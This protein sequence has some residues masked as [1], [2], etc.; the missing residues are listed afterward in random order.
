MKILHMQ[1]GVM[2]NVIDYC[3]DNDI[4]EII[5][6]GDL[7]DV[8]KS[9]S[10]KALAEWNSRFF[11]KLGKAG[12]SMSTVIGNHDMV[13]ENTI[14]PNSQTELLSHRRNISITHRPETKYFDGVQFL[15]IPWICKDNEEICL[16]AIKTSSAKICVL[17]PEIKGCTLQGS[18]TCEDGLSIKIF[19]HFDLVIAGHFHT[20]GVYGNVTYV[21]TPYQTSWNDYGENK[22]FH[23]LDTETA[24]MEFISVGEALCH[25]LVYDEDMD[26]SMDDILSIDLTD[27]YVKLTVENRTDFEKYDIFLAKLTDKGMAKLSVI[28]PILQLSGKDSDVTFDGDLDVTDTEEL[29]EEYIKDLYPERVT[30]LTNMMLGLHAEARTLL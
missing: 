3:V 7:F 25:R 23:I 27:K 1:I 13:F 2:E 24:T 6:T 16:N 22:G 17:H 11:D 29:I 19:D 10:T 30:K 21:G 8:R 28:E 4:T 20:R 14:Y 5:Q 15:F 12:I 9:T 18:A 26:T